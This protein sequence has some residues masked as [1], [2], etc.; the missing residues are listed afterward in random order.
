MIMA[1]AVSF[2]FFSRQGA[3]VGTWNIKFLPYIYI[4]D[5]LSLKLV[6]LVSLATNKGDGRIQNYLYF[7]I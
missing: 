2:L 7:S 1:I 3:K 4:H 6:S 5:S